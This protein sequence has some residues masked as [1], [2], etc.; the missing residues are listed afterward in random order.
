MRRQDYLLLRFTDLYL[1]S[2]PEMSPDDPD[3]NLGKI[4]KIF[5]ESY[6]HENVNVTSEKC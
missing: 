5:V 1:A 3:L 4:S 6:L 2:T